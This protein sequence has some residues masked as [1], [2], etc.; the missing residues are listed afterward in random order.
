MKMKKIRKEIRRVMPDAIRIV[1][2]KLCLLPFL[3]RARLCWLLIRGKS[4]IDDAVKR[5][6]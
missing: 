3:E 4:C 2:G 5:G 1:W 6:E